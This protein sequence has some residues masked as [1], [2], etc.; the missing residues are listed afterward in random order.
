MVP[1]TVLGFFFFLLLVAPGVYYQ[2]L[3]ERRN[4]QIRETAFREAA[5]VAL[6]SF[7]FSFSASAMIILFRIV[8][9]N[10]LVDF[11]IDPEA[12]GNDT[13]KYINSHTKAIVST[14]V[15][16]V[17]TAFS[18]VIAVDQISSAKL[19]SKFCAKLPGP[20]QNV[21][22]SVSTGS[23]TYE[24]TSHGLWWDMFLAIPSNEIAW[25]SI[26]LT[27][28]SRVSGFF[29]MCTSYDRF[30]NAEIAI[31]KGNEDEGGSMLVLDQQD[32]DKQNGDKP[33]E[34][35]QED[36]IWVRGDDISYIKVTYL[37]TYSP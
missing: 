17:L 13:Q 32:L 20:I 25:L 2:L 11:V 22:R 37:P 8:F 6:Y 10:L 9:P 5:R 1:Q 4:P 12:Y 14:I 27:D 23:R 21:L 33:Q 35:H 18:L 29:H 7:W 28:G 34:L 15:L 24:I 31:K 26:R 36:L 19:Y 30:E 16:E 3:R